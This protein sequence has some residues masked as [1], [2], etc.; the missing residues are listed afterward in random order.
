MKFIKKS[1]KF[2]FR[3]MKNLDYDWSAIDQHLEELELEEKRRANAKKKETTK[4]EDSENEEVEEETIEEEAKEQEELESDYDDSLYCV[5][6][7]KSF[8]SAK[9]FQNHEKSKKHKENVELLKKHMIEEEAELLGEN[10]EKKDEESQEEKIVDT[11]KTKYSKFNAIISICF[12]KTLLKI[13]KKAKKK[14]GDK[15]ELNLDLK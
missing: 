4:Q 1:T 7:D 12:C 15:I 8:Q 14:N 3:Q 5:A 6:C 9:S 2:F 11:Q 13:V 10:E